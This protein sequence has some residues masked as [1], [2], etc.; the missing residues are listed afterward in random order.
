ML[1]QGAVGI[2][3]VLR[4]G[5]RSGAIA[6]TLPRYYL[7][8]LPECNTNSGPSEGKKIRKYRVITYLPADFSHRNLLFHL[9]GR[10]QNHLLTRQD[11]TCSREYPEFQPETGDAFAGTGSRATTDTA[12]EPL[13]EDVYED[14][15]TTG[16]RDGSAKIAPTMFA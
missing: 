5:T 12:G 4:N 7:R 10:R 14:E 3:L 11:N 15:E 16:Y 13:V 1:Q 2:V 8:V 6:L 9:G